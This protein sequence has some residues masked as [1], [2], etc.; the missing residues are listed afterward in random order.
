MTAL[1]ATA[2]SAQVKGTRGA[3]LAAI[4][5]GLI[6]VFLAIFLIYP[7]TRIFYDA[8]TTEAGQFTLLNFQDFFDDSFYVRS[9]WKSMLLGVATVGTTSIIGVAV[10]F[11]LI[12]YEFPYRNAFSYPTL[13]PIMSHPLESVCGC[14]WTLGRT[15]TDHY[16][17]GGG[18]SV[19]PL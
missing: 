4:G 16:R 18:V 6:W 12:R 3:I 1:T 8:F 11:L 19:D 15:G 5:Y 2:G 14:T 9:F 13:L 10:A 7:L 17:R